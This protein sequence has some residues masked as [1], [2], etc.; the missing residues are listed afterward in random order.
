MRITVGPCCTFDWSHAAIPMC[1]FHAIGF[2]R[3]HRLTCATVHTFIWVDVKHAVT[4]IDAVNYAFVDAGFVFDVYT[5]K[6]DYIGPME[7]LLD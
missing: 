6:G 7:T 1:P 4:L 2:H 3:A 5:R